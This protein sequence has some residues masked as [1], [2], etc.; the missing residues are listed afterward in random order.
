MNKQFWFKPR[1]SIADI[2][3][4]ANWKGWATLLVFV[5]IVALFSQMIGAWIFAGFKPLGMGVWLF[6]FLFIV[7]GVF[8]K[9]CNRFTPGGEET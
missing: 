5:F 3:R 8:L 9:I 2:G 4:P 7:I 1:K 6:A